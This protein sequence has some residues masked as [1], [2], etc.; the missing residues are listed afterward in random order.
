MIY[1]TSEYPAFTDWIV[2]NGFLYEPFRLIDVGVQGGIHSRWNWLREY[3]ELW[4]FHP[5]SDVI[6]QLSADNPA[7]ERLHY[8]HMGLGDEDGT[9][10]FQRN[11][12]PYGSAHL[13]AE[14]SEN[15]LGRTSGGELPLGWSRVPIRRLDS[16]L[17]EGLFHQIDAI[18]LDCEGFEFQILKGADR[19]LT[20]TGVFAIESESNLKLQTE[21]HNPCH[22]VDIYQLIGR[23]GFEVYDLYY[24]RVSR[25]EIPGGYPHKGQPDT[26]D[27]LFLR[28]FGV[29][30]NL[31]SFSVDHLI[32]MMI[33]A[34]LYA[35]Q[36]VASNL[37]A[38]ASSRFSHRFNVE[39]ALE[40]L[41][42]EGGREA[43]PAIPSA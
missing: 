2:E 19:F 34:E 29:D 4:A 28:G 35:L 23:R 11:E 38:R 10:P 42:F 1:D 43:T 20:E 12:N 31:S 25:P 27:F 22:F 7:P 6:Q 17:R 16:L 33:V 15:H 21:R 41:R 32:K 5:L 13:P 36:D 37:L 24:Y 14:I 40:L 26:F 30:N 9:R 8:F 18:K 39:K 3:L